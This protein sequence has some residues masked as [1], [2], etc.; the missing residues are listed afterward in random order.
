MRATF[1][2]IGPLLGQV[3]PKLWDLF[4]SN[5]VTSLHLPLTNTLEYPHPKISQSVSMYYQYCQIICTVFKPTYLASFILIRYRMSPL[6]YAA[7]EGRVTVCEKLLDHGAEIN[8][9]EM[10]GWTVSLTKH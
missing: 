10:R 7:K 8:K 1:W 2:A 5:N 9:Q 4:R 6:M 3:Q